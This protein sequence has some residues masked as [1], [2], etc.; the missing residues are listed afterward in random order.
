MDQRGMVTFSDLV[1]LVFL[2]DRSARHEAQLIS[3]P[4]FF[5]FFHFLF[6]SFFLSF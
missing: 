6:H 1:L 4:L 2:E 5:S 3:P